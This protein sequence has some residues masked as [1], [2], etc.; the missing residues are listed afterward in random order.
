MS[1]FDLGQRVGVCL[2]HISTNW[3]HETHFILIYFTVL[4]FYNT[5]LTTQLS[6][7]QFHEE[8]YLGIKGYV[9][10]ITKILLLP[11]TRFPEVSRMAALSEAYVCE[12]LL[13][14]VFSSP[15]LGYYP[16]RGPGSPALEPIIPLP[17]LQ[18]FF[19]IH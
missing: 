6:S 10:P 16:E 1:N 14:R 13:R 12:R 15:T 4:F 19:P 3:S 11:P 9:S 18:C 7:S 5:W 17:F 8:R 2:S